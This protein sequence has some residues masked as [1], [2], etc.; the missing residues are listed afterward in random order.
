MGRKITVRIMQA[1]EIPAFVDAVIKT[2]CNICACGDE[3]YTIGDADLPRE[4]YLIVALW[5]QAIEERFGDRD[6][7]LLEIVAYLRSMGR[8]V[9]SA[10]V[11]HWSQNSP[12]GY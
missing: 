12:A 5:L 4:E 6:F 1:S 2:G 8:Y 10:D 11:E 3:Y 9:D 7:L